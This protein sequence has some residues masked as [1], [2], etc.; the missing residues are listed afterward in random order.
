MGD[1][2]AVSLDLSNYELLWPTPLFVTEGERI[3]RIT[4][5]SWKDQAKWLLTEAL[6][7]TT[8]VADFEEIPSHKDPAADPWA[9][10]ANPWGAAHHGKDQ[11]D[12]F[13]ELIKRASELRHAAAPRPYWPQRHG[14]GV[15]PDGRTARDARQDFARL[16]G[17]FADNGYLAE[18]FGEYCVDSRRPARRLRGDRTPPGHPRSV[19]PDPGDVG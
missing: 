3:L 5:S 1:D 4:G 2:V 11:C 17:D 16:I 19:A 14:S 6:A 7:G 18:V 9:T 8:A 13:E 10:P 15:F 12:W